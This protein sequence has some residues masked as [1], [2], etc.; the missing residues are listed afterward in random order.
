MD[1]HRLPTRRKQ[2]QARHL[3]NV[4]TALC[5][6]WHAAW[7]AVRDAQLIVK[8]TIASFEQKWPILPDRV[9]PGRSGVAASA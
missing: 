6:A 8:V 3:A 9:M 5:F 4:P 7:S 2:F 1:T